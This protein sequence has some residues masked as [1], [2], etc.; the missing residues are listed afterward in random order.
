MSHYQTSPKN[1]N[2]NY[3]LF[4]GILRL[5][6]LAYLKELCICLCFIV[7]VML[8]KYQLVCRRNRLRKREI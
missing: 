2:V 3:R 7:Y 6:N 5:K 1:N 8:R 4:T